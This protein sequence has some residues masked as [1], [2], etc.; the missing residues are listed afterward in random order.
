MNLKVKVM[1]NITMLKQQIQEKLIT[2]LK[3]KDTKK[4]NVFR[5]LMS[6]IKNKEID[7]KTELT[8]EE[9]VQVIRKQI[10]ELNDANEMFKKGNR[11]DLIEENNYQINILNEYLPQEISDEELKKEIELIK[12]E[13]KELIEKNPKAIFG[14]CIG[15]LKSKA[16]PKR[17]MNMLSL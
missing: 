11:H 2:A 7:K 5:F 3:E 9:I 4:T 12:Q 16:D 14:I 8:D 1:Y 6:S 10:K 15:K 17:I 13:N